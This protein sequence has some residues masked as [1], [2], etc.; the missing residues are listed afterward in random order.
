MHWK[1]VSRLHSR[2]LPPG[3]TSGRV[4]SFSAVVW[5]EIQALLEY[6]IR[7][8]NT[9]RRY[10]PTIIA[11]YYCSVKFHGLHYISEPFSPVMTISGILIGCCSSGSGEQESAAKDIV[12]DMNG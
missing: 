12:M 5:R 2:A 6:T 10:S 8:Y 1:A 11:S 4:P 3:N 7:T 9:R